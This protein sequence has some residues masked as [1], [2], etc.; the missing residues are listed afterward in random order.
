MLQGIQEDIDPIMIFSPDPY[1][2]R[3]VNEREFW[4]DLDNYSDAP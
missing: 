1:M 2:Q 3:L 4:D